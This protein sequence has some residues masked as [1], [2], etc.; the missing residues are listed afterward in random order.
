MPVRA[1]QART[2]LSDEPLGRAS[3][4]SLISICKP[5]M[6]SIS[7]S[8]S[9][10][11]RKMRRGPDHCQHSSQQPCEIFFKVKLRLQPGHIESMFLDFV[12][13]SWFDRRDRAVYL[14]LWY[15]SCRAGH[16]AP[17]AGDA[18]ALQHALRWDRLRFDPSLDNPKALPWL[19]V[20]W[21][22]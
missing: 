8:I 14:T 2:S 6:F 16:V 17:D 22:P 15:T 19:E 11:L 9:I 12:D 10:S 21:Q 3:R 7:I 13:G 20:I 5:L 18:H 1:E 4:M